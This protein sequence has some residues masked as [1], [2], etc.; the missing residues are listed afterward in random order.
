MT[1]IAMES[2]GHAINFG[3]DINLNSPNSD[4]IIDFSQLLNSPEEASF[5]SSVFINKNR[6]KDADSD[7][8]LLPLDMRIPLGS[9]DNILE[10]NTEQ[11]NYGYIIVSRFYGISQFYNSL[12]LLL[13]YV[14]AVYICSC[15]LECDLAGILK[16]FFST[17]SL[18]FSMFHY[19]M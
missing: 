15:I 13:L 8:E 17:C 3:N 10:D 16:V 7:D 12:L 14:C 9:T 1:V 11:E 5:S 2:N 4:P 18:N 19:Q 6:R